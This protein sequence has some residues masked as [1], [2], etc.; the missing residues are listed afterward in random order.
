LIIKTGAAIVMGMDKPAD[1]GHTVFFGG[2]TDIFQ[3]VS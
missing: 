3:E 1:A 2:L